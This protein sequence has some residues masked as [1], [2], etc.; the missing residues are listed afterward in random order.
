MDRPGTI[1]SLV[2]KPIKESSP[3]LQAVLK[4]LPTAGDSQPHAPN[5]NHV[6]AKARIS[7]ISTQP[8]V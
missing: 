7:R 6:D 5:P 4:S 8:N 3:A 2:Q 1:S